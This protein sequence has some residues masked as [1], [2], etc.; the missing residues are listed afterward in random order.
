MKPQLDILLKKLQDFTRTDILYLVRGGFWVGLGYFIQVTIGVVTTIALANFLSKEAFGMYQY[1]LSAAGILSVLTLSGLG[2][3]ITRAVAQGHDGVLRS[4]VR[5][6][7]KWS[8]SIVLA[9]GGLALYYYFND[10]MVLSLAF[11]IVGTF[12]PFIESF[13]LYENY[14]RGKEAFQDGVLL[15]AW[16][17]PLPLVALLTT[18]FFTDEVLILVL[19]YFASN[20]ISYLAVYWAVIRKYQPPIETHGETLTLSKHLSVMQIISQI[21][22]HIDKIILWQFLGGAAVAS[23]TIAQLATRYSGGLLNSLSALVLPKVSKRDLSTLKKTLPR[24]IWIFSVVMAIGTLGYITAAPFLFAI[25]FPEYPESVI[26]TQLIAVSLV[27]VPF[28]NYTH[29]FTAHKKI[30][31]QYSTGILMVVLYPTLLYLLISP[32]GVIGAVY[33]LLLTRFAHA[34]LINILFLRTKC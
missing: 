26:L 6:K 24:K 16:R 18:L 1:V 19:V 33:A 4:S 3:A 8:I 14:L 29:V 22:Q 17:K 5:I 32:Y 20:A 10:N 12:A 11:L 25:V 13:K 21:G 34:I 15:G 2:P 28:T 9:S 23:F 7:L 30:K 27:L 31:E